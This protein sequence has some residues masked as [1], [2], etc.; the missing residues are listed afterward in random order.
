MPQVDTVEVAV[1]LRE[2]IYRRHR[3]D[4]ARAHAA[5]NA[6]VKLG[7]PLRND[8]FLGTQIPKN[9]FPRAFRNYPNLWKL[10]LP[11]AFRA[12]YTVIGRPGRAVRVAVE[13]AGDHREYEKLFGYA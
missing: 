11:H 8:P 12:V 7:R 4:R 6:F 5:W 2:E 3:K 1:G 13:W 10:D 9:R